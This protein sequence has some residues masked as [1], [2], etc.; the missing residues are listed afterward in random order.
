MNITKLYI[1]ALYLVAII[2]ST[3][4]ILKEQYNIAILLILGNAFPGYKLAESLMRK[5]ED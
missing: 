2:C 1:L 5:N 4:F 3:L